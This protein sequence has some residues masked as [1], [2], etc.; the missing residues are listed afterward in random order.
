MK[1][2]VEETL[3]FQTRPQVIERASVL[4]LFLLLAVL[5][6]SRLILAIV[7]VRRGRLGLDSPRFVDESSQRVDHLHPKKKINF[8]H[9]LSEKASEKNVYLR[10]YH[11]AVVHSFM[12]AIEATNTSKLDQARNCG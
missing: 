11:P 12:H 4:F 6:L 3:E 1:T 2:Y 8:H 5:S 10:T 9:H 7:T